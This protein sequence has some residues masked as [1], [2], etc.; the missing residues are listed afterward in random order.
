MDFNRK[1]YNLKCI[2]VL[3]NIIKNNPKLRFCQI[4][5]ICG[6]KVDENIF[7]E[8]PIK[9]LRRFENS[10]LNKKQKR[11][12]VCLKDFADDNWNFFYKGFKY[13]EEYIDSILDKNYK[14]RYFEYI[15]EKESDNSE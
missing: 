4:L 14:F 1:E 5:E 13:S 3:E 7:Y 2:K 9:T 6:I 12:M 10:D 11:M 8:E 15:D